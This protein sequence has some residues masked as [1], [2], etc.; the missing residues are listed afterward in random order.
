[1]KSGT[2]CS[3]CWAVLLDSCYWIGR[4]KNLKRSSNPPILLYRRA[5]QRVGSQGYRYVKQSWDPKDAPLCLR[6]RSSSKGRSPQLTWP[7]YRSKF[8]RSAAPKPL[9]FALWHWANN[10]NHLIEPHPRIK[11]AFPPATNWWNL[12]TPRWES[13]CGNCWG[14]GVGW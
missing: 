6:Y 11:L 1:M 2:K 13:K 12:T 4:W 10:S 3:R 5:W 14:L 7:W 8:S 9:H